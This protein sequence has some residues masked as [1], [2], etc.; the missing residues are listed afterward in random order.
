MQYGICN[1]S[2]VPI[3]KEPG[4]QSEMT[5]MLLFG[6]VFK[7]NQEL[8]NWFEILTEFDNYPG[9][10]NKYQCKLITENF[11]TKVSGE[12]PVCPIDL[13]NQID[14]EDG[15][16]QIFCGS[17]LPQYDGKFFNIENDNIHAPN[18][19][20]DGKINPDLSFLKS[21]ALKYLNAPYLWGGR[22]P[23][24][25]DCSGFS[26]A[27]YK[28][29][30]IKIPRDSEQQINIGNT[31]DFINETKVGDLAF[32][33]NEAGKIVHVGILLENQQIIHAHGKVRIDKLDHHGIYNAERKEYSHKLRLIKRIIP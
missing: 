29:Q 19:C 14:S 13:I 23:F 12:N 4:S 2:S 25:L 5:S 27:L 7:I 11:F 18:N 26:Q 3:R 9:W 32:F 10:I 15:E 24:G 28:M 17:T 6:E 30:G 16:L 8:N 33:H 20:T 22:S 21:N 1:L 31:I